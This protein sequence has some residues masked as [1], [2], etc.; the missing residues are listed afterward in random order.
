MKTLK[1]LILVFAVVALS[2]CGGKVV[3]EDFE[4]GSLDGWTTVGDALSLV[5]AS[6]NAD[7]SGYQG[8]YYVMN[9]KPTTSS[10]LTSKEFAI[11]KDFINILVGGTRSGYGQPMA[12][13]E[14]LV[15]GE[16]V[17]KG[18]TTSASTKILEWISIDVKQYSGKNGQIRICAEPPVANSR[19]SANST[20]MVDQ[21]QLGNKKLSTFL[22]EY[23]VDV[24][25]SEQFLLIPASATQSSSSRISL[26]VDG[27]NVLGTPQSIRFAKEKI[28]HY[29]PINIEQYKGKKLTISI[30]AVDTK[31]IAYGGIKQAPAGAPEMDYSETYR[32]V[33][34]MTPWFGWTNDPNGMVYHNGVYH[35]AYQYNPYGISHG[36]MH[37]GHSTST[38][39]LHWEHQ[40]PIVAPDELGSIFSGS[41]VVDTENTT[42]YGEGSI[43]AIYTSA[44]QGQR[45][46]IAYSNDGGYTFT[47][48]EK[49]PV[50][51]DPD[52]RNFRDPKVSWIKDQWV[53]A[54]ATGQTISF[55]G[56]KDLK[57]WYFLSAF[58][59]DGIGSH[60]GV[61]ECP[62][63]LKFDYNGQE[64]WVLFVSINPGS[65]Y[66]GSIT[67]YFIGS[68][69]GKEFKADRLNYPLWLDNGTDNY[70]GVTFSNTGD[71][72]IFMGWMS[73]W[74]YASA[75][76][77]INFKSGMTI[78]RDLSIKHN[79]K[80][81]V[82]ASV[83]SPEVYNGRASSRSFD[84]LN[85][86]GSAKIE[87]MLNNNSGAYEL[88]LTVVPDSKGIFTVKLL[89]SKGEHLDFI[90]DTKKETLAL[91]RTESG[92]TDFS[93][94]FL[95]PVEAS[96]V[97]K[98]EYKIQLFIDKHSSE[99]FLND[100]DLVF[101]NLMFPTEPYNTLEVVS[102]NCKVV[103]KDISIHEMR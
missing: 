77:T 18:T 87:S 91:G 14:L 96:I 41:S 103:V 99:L 4:S 85:V 37:W 52:Q 54:L 59:G 62:D 32:Q 23:V 66:G 88:D 53:M 71:R 47:K 83:P 28:D 102:E 97:A 36:N 61:W 3:I 24:V 20:I 82:L 95:S 9:S 12:Y 31:D 101:T 43:I 38:D 92:L 45:Q 75:T 100:G 81:L 1:T 86:S 42:G 76:P 26:F 72:K 17:Y 63:L 55:Y 25:A 27:E 67:Q 19:M 5:S 90:F 48:Y 60:A 21:I 56:S 64:K 94:A 35:L 10:S 46:S 34:H 16:S 44:G 2:S 8:G 70:A 30:T 74:Q 29:V 49:N 89:N 78:P 68:F 65:P 69:N 13:V 22:D 73:N 33:Y 93:Q 50:L 40:N 58:G 80:H 98:S 51:A 79:G 57:E 39:L 11:N 15:D 6:S 7:I 84:A